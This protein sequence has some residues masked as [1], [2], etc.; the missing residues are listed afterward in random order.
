MSNL[1]TQANIILSD[2]E[3]MSMYRN[4]QHK[5]KVTFPM[6]MNAPVIEGLTLKSRLHRAASLFFEQAGYRGKGRNTGTG[7][8]I[9][10]PKMWP[11]SGLSEL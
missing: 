5:T 7:L 9:V 6:E 10:V 3:L 2:D 4:Q 11:V 8:V 1:M